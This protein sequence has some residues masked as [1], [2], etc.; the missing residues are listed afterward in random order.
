MQAKLYGYRAHDYGA[1][2]Q[3]AASLAEYYTRLISTKIV[4]DGVDLH[5]K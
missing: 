2:F 4:L 5:F 1:P 3:N